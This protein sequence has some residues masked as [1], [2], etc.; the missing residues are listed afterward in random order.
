[1]LTSPIAFDRAAFSLKLENM[2]Y[3]DHFMVE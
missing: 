2:Y 3:Y 1:M